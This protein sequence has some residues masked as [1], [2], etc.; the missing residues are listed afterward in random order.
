MTLPPPGDPRRP[1]YLAIRSTRLLGVMFLLLGLVTFTPTL[2][3]NIRL[4]D[5][6]RPVFLSAMTHFVPGM[7]YCVSAVLLGRRRRSAVISA[8]GLVTVHCVMIT[9][10]LAAYSGLLVSET[11]DPKFL[12]FALVV[13]LLAMAG[14]GQLIFQLVK[15]LAVV[16]LPPESYSEDDLGENDS[17]ENDP[18][19]N[20]PAH[21]S[22]MSVV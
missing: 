20:D 3:T 6:P 18:G 19:E 13:S 8:L 11:Q 9:G 12:I 4:L 15:S 1:L 16:Q 21:D 22:V 2:K 5:I 14:L 10:S 17:D 7:L